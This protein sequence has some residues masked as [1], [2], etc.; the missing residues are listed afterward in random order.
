MI[1]I[2]DY[3]KIIH[4]K[5]VLDHVNLKLDAGKVYGLKGPNGCGKTM[6]MR[7]ICGLIFPTEGTVVIDGETIG[8]EI[9]FPRSVGVLLENPAFIPYY[10]GLKNLEL[11]ASIQEKICKEQ[12][13]KTLELVGLDPLDKKHYRKYSLGMKQKLGI[14]GAI[15]E[16]PDI[17]ILDE[18]LNALDTAGVEVVHGIVRDFKSDG[19][20]V[21]LACH[22]AAELEK[23]ADEIISIENGKVLGQEIVKGTDTN[24]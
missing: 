2:K 13:I 15:M 1:E 21:I 17:L 23:M 8:K 19:K 24:A 6:L 20:T 9:D 18:P 22:D 4:K 7:A 5:T 3:S 14:A 10:S 12:I 16:K 11:L